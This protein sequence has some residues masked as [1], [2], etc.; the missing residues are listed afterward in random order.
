MLRVQIVIEKDRVV[1]IIGQQLLSFGNV[2]RYVQVVTLEAPREPIVPAR[3]VFQNK[4][5]NRMS[6]GANLEQ[7][8]PGEY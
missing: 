8:Q 4:D 5:A 2:L 3:I 7:T 6:L 1:G